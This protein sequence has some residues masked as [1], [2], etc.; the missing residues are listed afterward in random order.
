MPKPYALIQPMASVIDNNAAFVGVE[1]GM[2]MLMYQTSDRYE[3][4]DSVLYN[5]SGRTSVV[6]EGVQYYLVSEDKIVTKEVA[7]TPP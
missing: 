1:S 2:I 6:Y 4:G 7:T 5:P 3:G